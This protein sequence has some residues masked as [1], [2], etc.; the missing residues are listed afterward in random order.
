MQAADV[1]T[2]LVDLRSAMARFFS[3]TVADLKPVVIV[4]APRQLPAIW[5]AW[6]LYA[7]PTRAQELI[8]RSRAPHPA[9][10]STRFEALAP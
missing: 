10:L 2:A 5:H 6:R 8:D 9:F 3:T 7:D 4:T 1:F